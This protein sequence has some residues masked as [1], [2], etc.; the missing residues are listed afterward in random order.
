MTSR[1][2]EEVLPAV[3]HRDTQVIDLT[4]DDLG[5]V[6]TTALATNAANNPGEA[7]EAV[8]A[9]ICD[10]AGWPLGIWWDVEDDP[11]PRL[12]PAAV[13]DVS[14]GSRAGPLARA[15]R[16]VTP[17]QAGPAGALTSTSAPGVLFWRDPPHGSLDEVA[18]DVG[19]TM[20]TAFG[21]VAN[22]RV[23]GVLE[24]FGA[25]QSAPDQ[26]LLSVIETACR[27]L[28]RVVERDDQ[29]QRLRRQPR[30]TAL[31]LDDTADGVIVTAVDGTIAD[32]N[33]A[34]ERLF[35]WTAREVVDT[36][37]VTELLVPSSLRQLPEPHLLDQMLTHG[38]TVSPGGRVRLTLECSDGG[39]IAVAATVWQPSDEDG[40]LVMV[41]SPLAPTG[42]S[43]T[44][45]VAA[46]RTAAPPPGASTA[47][48]PLDPIA[49]V[50]TRGH[51]LAELGDRV[52]QRPT[53]TVVAAL[54]IDR[55]ADV[56]QD[57]GLV[58]G[59]LVLRAVGRRLADFVGDTGL[60][61]RAGGDEFLVALD[62]DATAPPD[63]QA[64]G[65]RLLQQF[66]SELEG[67]DVPLL[68]GVTVGIVA[69]ADQAAPD[70]GLLVDGAEAA[71]RSASQRGARRI[72]LHD[73]SAEATVGGPRGLGRDLRTAIDKE[74]FEVHYQPL[75]DLR[76]QRPCGAE[77]LVRWRHPR[78]GLVPPGQ[79][80]PEAERTGLVRA[81]GRQVLAAACREAVG[82]PELDGTAL[83]L[84][85]NVSPVQ[86]DD[87]HFPA[88]VREVVEAAGLAP[89]RLTLEITESA[90]AQDSHDALLPLL[91]LRDWG[92]QLA[93][94]DFGAGHSSLGRLQHLPFDQLKV[95]RFLI[96]HVASVHEPLPVL[97]AAAQM[98]H[99][100]GMTVVAEG[101]ETPE[102]LAAAMRVECDRAQG[103]LLAR[104]QTPTQ[105]A[106][107]LARSV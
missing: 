94:D 5:L 25:P 16:P 53:T 41:V 11:E 33:A 43:P 32:W 99:A 76:T 80:I 52:Q 95:D 44:N 106:Q 73:P 82:W 68:I 58:T 47:P 46:P 34:A 17:G 65:W 102:Q 20:G 39:Q 104:P 55:L 22:Q 69:A 75:V 57:H 37:H 78:H 86:L 79:F 8:V 61:G 83:G 14:P 66:E 88:Y 9:A 30:P 51:F 97:E 81:I 26:P 90:L 101:V 6:R 38:T 59:D 54:D 96:R 92:I 87:P 2:E 85:V 84:N 12:V 103:Y 29:L 64:T 67:V 71:L 91:A 107:F 56:N 74:Q 35:G 98:A 62:Q 15:P 100:L 93:V 19:L 7:F 1:R 3:D 4:R 10:T 27:Q 105:L 31:S 18:I 23:A 50:A 28:S 60:V 77:A 63:L 89:E 40:G 49:G 21:V 45:A 70:A 36:C 48:T 24:F 42:T 13:M 72:G